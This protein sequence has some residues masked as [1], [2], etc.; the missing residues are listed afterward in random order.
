MARKAD[1]RRGEG[2]RGRL[3]VALILA[4]SFLYISM[5]IL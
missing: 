4:G 3:S 2:R 5:S 1:G